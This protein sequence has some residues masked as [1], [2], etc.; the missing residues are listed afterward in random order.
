MNK[1]INGI[2]ERR[3]ISLFSDKKPK[4]ETIDKI[5]EESIK[6]YPKKCSML[7]HKVKIFGPEFFKDKRKIVV[8]TTCDPRFA[9][10]PDTPEKISY[11]TESWKDWIKMYKNNKTIKKDIVDEFGTY[12][13]NPE[14]LAPYVL[15]FYDNEE[16]MERIKN[17]T[18]AVHSDVDLNS[19]QSR[20]R[21][22]Q[23]SAMHGII[24]AC[25][26]S[27]YKI[28]SS[29]LANISLKTKFNQN[30][31][32]DNVDLSKIVLILCL[33]Y[34]DEKTKW[35]PKH[36]QHYDVNQLIEWQQL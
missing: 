28:S 2:R 26:A 8:Q 21:A 36:R 16:K 9:A 31:I 7:Y 17:S 29:F 32:S 22:L 24:T 18:T 33:G 13:Y 27:E 35:N 10:L 19:T 30:A 15:I 12:E 3:S 1:N 11:L 25:I 34:P 5:L 4:K 6:Y 23:S 20:E 14:I